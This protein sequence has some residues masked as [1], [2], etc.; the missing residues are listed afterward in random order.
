MKLCPKETPRNRRLGLHIPEPGRLPKTRGEY[1][2]LNTLS[3]LAV[4]SWGYESLQ[5]VLFEMDVVSIESK[6]ILN[7]V[8]T[9]KNDNRGSK[10]I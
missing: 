3:F 9:Y 2:F 1:K 8:C 10:Q 4:S 7:G 5:T 6:G